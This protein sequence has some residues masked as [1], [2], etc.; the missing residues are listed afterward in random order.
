MKALRPLQEFL[1]TET[2]AGL[3]LLVMVPTALFWANGPFAESYRSLWSTDLS[4][5]LGDRDLT[6]DL[7]HWVNDALMALFFFVV[8]LE[9]KRELIDGQLRDRRRALTPVVAAVGG[10]IAPALIYVA[11]NA[12]TD[13]VSGWGI[14]MATD[15]AIVLGFLSLIGDRVPPALKTFLLTLAIVDDV[16]AIIVIA[17]FYPE[18]ALDATAVCAALACFLA[19]HLFHRSGIR[20]PV[21]FVLLVA[22]AWLATYHAGVHATLAG[23]VLAF[24]TPGRP[25]QPADRAKE[26]VLGDLSSYAA[27]SKTADIARNSVSSVEWYQHVFHPWSS[28]LVLPVFALAN[29]GVSLSMDSLTDSLSSH[30]TLGVALGL[31]VGKPIGI[32]VATF[33]AMKVLRGR[34]PEGVRFVDIAAGSVLAAIGFTVSLFIADLAFVHRQGDVDALVAEAKVGVLIASLTAGI[35]GFVLLSV[36]LRVRGQRS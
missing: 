35:V 1:R 12:G 15:I 21:L 2:A 16:G 18:H 8:G 30:V 14:P 27:A 9:I 6:L 22:G 11:A 29:A 5:R 34:L 24:L 20:N 23:V 17:V 10:M 31:L 7:R 25:P 33:V 19:I 32:C 36:V 4:L 28:Y 26:D 13:E 3:L